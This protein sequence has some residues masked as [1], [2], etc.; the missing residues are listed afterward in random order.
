[1]GM[2][3]HLTCL[4][5]ITEIMQFVF[6]TA[7]MHTNLILTRTVETVHEMNLTVFL[8]LILMHSANPLY[9]QLTGKQGRESEGI[10]GDSAFSF[11]SMP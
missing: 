9:L 8:F 7:Y 6:R 2:E 4:C 11:P 3:E 10:I 5:E 1:M